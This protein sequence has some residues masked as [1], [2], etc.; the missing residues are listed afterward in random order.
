MGEAKCHQWPNS[1]IVMGPGSSITW[2]TRML[3]AYSG[4]QFSNRQ[5][6]N[7]GLV[8]DCVHGGELLPERKPLELYSSK[9]RAARGPWI[10]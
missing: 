10:W 4:N 1:T 9:V 2:P 3:P 7:S 8:S 6:A 5:E